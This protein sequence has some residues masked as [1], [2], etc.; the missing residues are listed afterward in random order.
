MVMKKFL[1]K[2]KEYWMNDKDHGNDKLIFLAYRFPI[3]LAHADF[4]KE[5]ALKECTKFY[6][7]IKTRFEKTTVHDNQSLLIREIRLVILIY[8]Y[9]LF[10]QYQG[11]IRM[12]IVISVC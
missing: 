7:K 1:T 6:I 5:K 2:C 12:L 8:L 11:Q 9:P 10:C 3:L 4:N